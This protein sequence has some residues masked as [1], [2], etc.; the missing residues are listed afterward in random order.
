MGCFKSG[1]MPKD[2]V[3]DVR[4]PTKQYV[5][6]GEG[7]LS[8]SFVIAKL[9]QAE[10]LTDR[11]RINFVLDNGD[12]ESGWVV[13]YQMLVVLLKA[14]VRD[15]NIKLKPFV[16]KGLSEKQEHYKW[17]VI[18]PRSIKRLLLAHKVMEAHKLAD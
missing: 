8:N 7:A 4:V 6:V 1:A 18:N 10:E 13:S 5:V 11:S 16:G 12:P 17:E 3:V 9:K 14:M 2:N 15:G